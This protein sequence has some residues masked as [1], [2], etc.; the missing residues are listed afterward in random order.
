MDR[1]IKRL[2][3]LGGAGLWMGLLF[4]FSHQPLVRSR[5][6]SLVFAERL[7]DLW[8][9]DGISLGQANHYVRKSAHFIAYMILALILMN[10]L[11]LRRQTLLRSVVMAGLLS[12]LF[13]ASDEF[14][15]LFVEGR[16]GQISDVVLDSMGAFFGIGLY[17]IL[18]RNKF[19]K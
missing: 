3:W 7:V 2:I 1:K 11:R 13:A 9:I 10:I 18:F 12:I 16:G 15:Q 17:S 6:L 4:Y 8:G 14:H 19:R 5:G